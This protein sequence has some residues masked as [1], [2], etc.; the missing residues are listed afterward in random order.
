MKEEEGRKRREV[1]TLSSTLLIFNIEEEGRDRDAMNEGSM[2]QA[3]PTSLPPFSPPSIPLPL[4]SPPHPIRLPY[5]HILIYLKQLISISM[6]TTTRVWCK[7]GRSLEETPLYD[8][9]DLFMSRGNILILFILL[10]YN[11]RPVGLM[12]EEDEGPI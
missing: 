8:P 5:S 4:S 7:K 9:K 12:T 3:T 2:P 6:N 1:K 11:S 10:F